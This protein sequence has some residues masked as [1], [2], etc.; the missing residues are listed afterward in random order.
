MGRSTQVRAVVCRRAVVMR[1]S[2]LAV[3]ASD[4]TIDISFHP[5]CTVISGVGSTTRESMI[6]EL[7][8]GLSTHRSGTHLEVVTDAGRVLTIFRP[9]DAPHRVIDTG[10]RREV[11]GSFT[12]ADGT[13]D[14]LDTMGMDAATARRTARLGP[15]D[16]IAST[17]S[18]E[19]IGR[20]GRVDQ[21]ALWSDAH[22]VQIA[23]EALTRHEAQQGDGAERIEDVALTERIDHNY[24]AREAAMGQADRTRLLAAVLGTVSLAGAAIASTVNT[25][26]T[27]VLIGIAVVA[28]ITAFVFRARVEYYARQLE[29]ALEKS[30]SDSYLSYQLDRIDGYIDSEH[31]RRHRAAVEADVADALQ[32]W[33]RTAGDVDVDWATE[34]RPAI[35]AAARMDAVGTAG[36]STDGALVPHRAGVDTPELIDAL[37]TRFGACRGLGDD[38]ESFPLLLDEPFAALDPSVRPALL[39]VLLD[40]SVTSQVILLT[41]SEDITSWARLEEMTGALTIVGPGQGAAGA[42]DPAAPAGTGDDAAARATEMGPAPAEEPQRVVD[43]EGFE[44]S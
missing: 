26:A 20:L 16:L 22:R 4:R 10:E 44:P 27:F 15:N 34:H 41:N 3:Q 8:G 36:R 23:R 6:Q 11:T 33:H 28:T 5:R 21:K 13:I 37:I 32:R 25:T 1:F 12:R 9:P 19:L 39:G 38:D 17:R 43:R 30:G 24:H 31:R 40:Q 18:S 35:E 7:L 42:V 2:R 14:L 29:D